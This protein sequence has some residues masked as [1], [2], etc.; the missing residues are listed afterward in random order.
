MTFLDDIIRLAERWFERI[1]TGDLLRTLY[2]Y[3]LLNFPLTL[4][5]HSR[6]IALAD[7]TG[8]LEEWLFLLSA[9]VG[10]TA[11]LYLLLWL[12]LIPI[13]IVIP[14]RIMTLVISTIAIWL[15]NF[16]S[17]FDLVIYNMYRFHINGLVLNVLTTGGV[18]DSVSL[19][20]VTVILTIALILGLLVLAGMLH[21]L[22]I[23]VRKAGRFT[24]PLPV[25][26]SVTIIAILL[27][28][29]VDKAQYARADLLNRTTITRHARLLPLYQ[30][31]TIRKFAQKHW[32]IEVNREW[33]LKRT[34]GG[35]LNYPPTELE[36]D[37]SGFKPNF[38]LIVIDSW[39]YDMLDAAVTPNISAYAEEAKVFERHYSGGN[40]TRFGIFSLLYGLHGSYWHT[41]LAERKGPVLIRRL[42]DAGYALK[43]ISSTQLTFPELRRTAFVDIPECID[44]QIEGDGARI[45]DP[46]QLPLLESWLDTLPADQPFFAVMLLDAPHGGCDYDPS[47]ARFFPHVS[48][49]NYLALNKER[50]ST[51]YLNHYKNA[52]YFD[53]IVI[54]NVLDMLDDRGF[55]ENTVVM[56]TGDHGEEFYERGY[57]GHTGAFTPEQVKVPFV[58]GG[59]GVGKGRVDRLTSHTDLA[60]TILE[61]IGCNTPAE[62]YSQGISML[63]AQS[64]RGYVVSTGW[65]EFAIIDTAVTLVISSEMYNLVGIKVYDSEY[66]LI[67]ED[68]SELESRLPYLRAVMDEFSRFYLR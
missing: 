68:E 7:T 14:S 47:I 29:I 60:P 8:T 67:T 50:D 55:H 21:W 46:K 58:M 62:E 52:I 4:L 15:L 28:N 22:V 59:P 38:I 39:R 49:I 12:I 45:R 41:F 11:M 32:G 65:E 6:Y 25:L 9:L 51:P 33:D 20:V 66:N 54:G 57:W 61:L 40:A 2:I 18:S 43:I 10:N 27:L 13:I 5:I 31:L 48:D 53:D 64:E 26:Y 24:W 16:I 36:F 35:I 17:I 56:I 63:L 37:E 34:A 3:L 1:R 42:K 23:K 19:G 30:P 44:D